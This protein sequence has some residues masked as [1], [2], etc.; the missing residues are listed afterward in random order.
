M[1]DVNEEECLAAGLDPKAVLAIARRLDRAGRDA[2]KLGLVVF[3]GS[4]HGSL[5]FADGRG[6][7]DRMLVVADLGPGGWDGGDGACLPDENGLLR[8]E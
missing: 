1:A 4:G 7:R 5:R 8:G 6:V 3:G 2:R